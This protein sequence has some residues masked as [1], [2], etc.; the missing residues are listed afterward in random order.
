M[1]LTETEKALLVKGLSFSLPP[2]Q[3][4]YSDYLINFELFYRSI[5]NLK[6]LSGDNLDFIK[7]RI[8]DT[9]LTSFH[10]YNAN[11]LQHLSNEE[12]EALKALSGNCN[13]VIQ[14]ADKG[15]SVV[16]VEKD[17][18]VRHMETILSDLNKFEKVSFKKGILN[19]S[20]NHEKIINNYLKRLEKS[21]SLSTEQY[22]KIK[23]VRNRPGILYGLCKLHKAITEV[24]PPF[25]PILSAIGTPSYKLAKFLVPKIS[26][27]TF[28]EF[29]VKGYFAFAEEIVHQDSK[30]FMGS[31]DVDSLF[32]NIP[33][34]ETI[35][36]CT[37]LLYNNEDVIEGIN[38]SE[39]KNLL[40][41]AT[42]ES[43]FIFNDV[44]YKQK[45]GVAMRLSL[46]PTMANVFL[47]FFEI[48]W[49]EQCPKE[50]KLVF[51]RRYVDDIFVL[52][53]SAEHLSKFCDYFNTR[54]PNMSF[55]FEQEKNGKLLFLDVEV[56]REKGKFVTTVYR[57][58]TFSGVYTHFDSFLPTVYKFGMVFYR[59][60]KICS[61]WTNFHEE[62]SFLK[63]VFLKNGYPLSFIDNCFKTFVDK[64]FIKRLQLA[65]VEKKTFLLEK[66][67]YK[68]EQ[69]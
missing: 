64:L 46:G 51:Y 63:Y 19:F 26:S 45:N 53:K 9:A 3:L 69:S 20:I 6:I 8:K 49:L 56:S 41:L 11:V 40:S 54:H 59:C 50:F 7:T 21:G 22:K 68:L 5:D 66:F 42:Q 12:F 29:T 36:I 24:C 60:F 30:L 1:S 55:S 34:E 4:S 43:H 32:T 10:N 58:P 62:L 33:L 37:N 17:V 48:K 13:L 31:F 57:K 27:V 16:I 18:Y 67:P 15:N 52:F 25:R 28:N 47:S 35:N 39:F 2:K 61:D 44:L 65:T 14:K 23:A 38:K